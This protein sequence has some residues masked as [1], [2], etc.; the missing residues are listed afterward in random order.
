MGIIGRHPVVAAASLF[1]IALFVNTLPPAPLPVGDVATRGA[2]TLGYYP[3]RVLD[4]VGRAVVGVWDGYMELVGVKEEN[5]RLRERLKVLTAENARLWAAAYENAGLR[6]ML[7]FKR[8]VPYELLAATVIASSPTALRSEMVV[9]DRGEADGVA[10]GMPVVTG[11]GVVGRVFAA[12]RVS[13]QVILITDG[14]SAVDA[15][16]HRTRTRAIVRGTGRGCVMEYVEDPSVLRAGDTV[17]TSGKDGFFPR[18][19]LIGTVERAGGGGPVVVRPAVDIDSLDGVFVLLRR[20]G[21][22]VAHE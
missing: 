4:A 3:Q 5:R 9:I 10:P 11:E 17:V 15:V 21:F 13:S 12:G 6:R 18:G 7:A 8:A 2:L 16:V 14:A 1:V 22:P 19:L 20:A